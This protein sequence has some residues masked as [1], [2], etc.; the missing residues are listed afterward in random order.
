MDTMTEAQ[1]LIPPLTALDRCDHRA[2]GAQAYVAVL[3]KPDSL[4]PLLF[5]GHHFRD[6]QP[7]L[8]AQNPHAVRDDIK[9][10]A[11]RS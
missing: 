7:A 4:Y 9:V 3:L 6:V 5:C 10:L 1:A 11:G 8:L 2:C